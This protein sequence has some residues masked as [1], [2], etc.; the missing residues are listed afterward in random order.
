MNQLPIYLRGELRVSVEQSLLR[1][2]VVSILPMGRKPR[3]VGDWHA[4]AP[5][6]PR[7][8]QRKTRITQAV[9]KVVENE[10]RDVDAKW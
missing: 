2:P 6:V 9:L 4:G 1:T 10:L 8:R 3:E 7:Q 5:V